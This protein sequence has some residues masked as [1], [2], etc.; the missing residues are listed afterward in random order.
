MNGSL[1]AGRDV[2]VG[3]TDELEIPTVGATEALITA[4]CYAKFC[5]A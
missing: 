1:I 4:S 3:V 2:I 5:K